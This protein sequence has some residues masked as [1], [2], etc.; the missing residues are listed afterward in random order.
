MSRIPVLIAGAGPVG[1]LS[2]LLLARQGIASRLID[3]RPRPAEAPKAHAVNPRT[4]E[5]CESVGVSAEGLRREGASANDAGWVRFVGTLTG[6]EFGALPYER[7]DD[8]ALADTPYPLT[9]IPQPKF[10]AALAKAIEAEPLITFTRGIACTGLVE[11]PDGVTAQLE[12]EDGRRD[13]L[14][15]DYLIAADGAGSRLRDML[16]IAMEGPEVLQHNL[17]IHFE[18]DLRALTD[19]RPGVLYF[20]F[21]PGT[22]GVFIAYD[23]GRTWV[24]MHP[25]DPATEPRDSFDEAR[26]GQ[27][28]EAAIGTT[29]PALKIRHVSPW[30]MSAQVAECYRKGRVFLAGDAAHRFPPTG[31]LGLNTGAVDTQ[32]LAWKLAAVL[33]GE[34]GEALL[35][36]YE[37]ERRPVA[38]VNCEQS[39]TNAS[40]LFELF[41]ALYGRDPARMQAH[42]EAVA[43]NPKASAELAAAVEAQRPHFDSFNLQLGYRYA[44]AATIGAPA[45]QAAAG[46]DISDYRPCWEAGAHVPHRLV[47]TRSGERVSL[48]SLLA[49]DRFAILAGPGGTSWREAAAATGLTALRGGWD[50]EDEAKG[51]TE[52]TGLPKDGA[53]LVRPDGHIA[54]RFEG[55][56]ENAAALLGEALAQVLAR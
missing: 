45:L 41:G 27:L 39:L 8:S 33:K 32:N 3:R 28:I 52:L 51:W 1:Q 35:D 55:G 26:C 53:L 37:T 38:Q 54:C 7:Q 4:L 42:Y 18:A 29:P 49:A 34:A 15:C 19:A 20:L 17:M 25:H 43:A 50:F 9:N 46:V 23:R 40:K 22:S 30:T 14:T 56:T 24:L 12:A 36:T 6:T 10:E 31:G 48:L 21:Q 11:V 13:T 5:I 2:A 16:G 44:S 47:K